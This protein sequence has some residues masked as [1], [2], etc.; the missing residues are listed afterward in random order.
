DEETKG[1]SD[2]VVEMAVKMAV[3]YGYKGEDLENFR[4]GAFL[5]DIGKMGVPDGILLKPG[6]LTEEEWVLMRK[7]PIF[8][9]QLLKEIPF[10]KNAYEIPYYHH[11]RWNGSGYPHGLKGEDIP[12]SAR[13]FAVVD[14]WDALSNDRPYRKAWKPE[15]VKKYIEDNK[16]IQFDP[17]IVETFFKLF[18]AGGSF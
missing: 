12:L 4:N 15:E 16:E 11:E 6:T 18:P 17:Q 1:H 7:H 13:I 10:L 2:R 3:E 14:V 9:Y 8:A 5:H